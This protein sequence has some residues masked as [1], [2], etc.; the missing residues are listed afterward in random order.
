MSDRRSSHPTNSRLSEQVLH[1]STDEFPIF[2]ATPDFLLFSDAPTT[3][4]TIFRLTFAQYSSA[5]VSCCRV[6]IAVLIGTFPIHVHCLQ[7]Y[8]CI[9]I[10]SLPLSSLVTYY[11][12]DHPSLHSPYTLL[13]T[14]TPGIALRAILMGFRVAP[15]GLLIGFRPTT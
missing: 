15:V 2:L 5:D 11:W 7:V 3:R 1:A 12:T 10:L 8:W 6:A 4:P 9:A 13:I 14:C